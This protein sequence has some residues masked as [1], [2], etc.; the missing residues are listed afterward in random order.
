MPLI[1]FSCSS[2]VMLSSLKTFLF[3]FL[4]SKPPFFTSY[5][6]LLFKSSTSFFFIFSINSYFSPFKNLFTSPYSNQIQ[7]P[8]FPL[9]LFSFLPLHPPLKTSF[10]PISLQNTPSLLQDTARTLSS[11]L[12]ALQVLGRF[13][14]LS[15]TPAHRGGRRPI[16]QGRREGEPEWVGG[17]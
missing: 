13:H 8:S 2:R 7:C 14:P 3:P 9:S 15:L 6:L 1:F 10:S 5:K 16:L 11:P 17:L 4:F 12:A